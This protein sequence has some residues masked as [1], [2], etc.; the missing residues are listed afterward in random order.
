MKK[1]INFIALAA[2]MTAGFVSTTQANTLDDLL[3]QVK[4]DRVSVAKLDKKRE[5][6]FKRILTS[7][8]LY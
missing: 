5:A 7:K 2:I 6:E 8:N 3:K 4:T 1:V